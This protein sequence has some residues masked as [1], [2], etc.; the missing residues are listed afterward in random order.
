MFEPSWFD[1]NRATCCKQEVKFY[2]RAFVPYAPN[3]P[4][5][6]SDPCYRSVM[7][8][9]WA[10][11]GSNIE[12]E[13]MARNG[14]SR[15]VCHAQSRFAAEMYA[16]SQ[17]VSYHVSPP[18]QP[19]SGP[20]H[21]YPVLHTG[22]KWHPSRPLP[23]HSRRG[24]SSSLTIWPSRNTLTKIVWFSFCCTTWATFPSRS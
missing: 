13:Q 4:K 16:F 18:N 5:S 14:Q 15:V 20:T 22:T 24:V 9:A 8:N 6:Q 21:P 7:A 2:F 10:V 12:E 17:S 19:D 11:G 23:P 1:G 3:I